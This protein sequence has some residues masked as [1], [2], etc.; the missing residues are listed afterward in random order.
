MTML[1]GDGFD[2]L[3]G[4][5]SAR[6]DQGRTLVALSGPPGSGKSTVANRLQALITRDLGVSAVVVGM[7]GFHF[8]DA[9]LLARGAMTRK[10][11][12]HTFDV[13]GLAALLARLHANT[14]SEVAA[15]VFDRALELSR[16]GALVV[17][18]EVR[19]VIVEGNY[20]LVTSTP[21]RALRPFFHLTARLKAPEEILTARLLQRWND[22]GIPEADGRRRVE[23]NDLPNGRLVEETSGE[24]DVWLHTAIA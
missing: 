15:P 13:G 9:V 4:K 19:V 11:A 18:R 10:G 5:I 7:D 12:P 1:H 23:A 16:A 2:D 3:L 20:L 21:W 17:S 8:D 14:E 22:L 6:K 24:P